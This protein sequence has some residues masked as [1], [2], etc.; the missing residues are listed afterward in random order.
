MFLKYLKI[1][2]YILRRAILALLFYLSAMARVF[3]ANSSPQVGTVVPS[4]GASTHSQQFTFISTYVD[5]D[6]W[7]NIQSTHFLINA[8]AN[9]T[10]CFHG[11][12]NQNTNKLY[13]RSDDGKNWLGGF[14]PHSSNTIEN[15]FV[16]IDCSKT[17]VSGTATILTIRWSI[18]FKP[19]FIGVKNTYLRVTDDSNA[20]TNWAKKG[21]FCILRAPVAP[22][23]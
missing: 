6:G 13:L 1:N 15:S 16:K 14:A 22:P 10:N 3:A 20:S 4:S 21:T 2:K 7:Q 23:D 17:S 12:Y 11:Y 9:T 8:S 18:L 5:I 19:N